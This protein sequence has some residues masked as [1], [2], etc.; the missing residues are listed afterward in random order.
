MDYCKE[1]FQLT[2]AI[3]HSYIKGEVVKDRKKT[4]QENGWHVIV[5]LSSKLR[6]KN[7]GCEKN[8]FEIK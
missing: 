7:K 4:W 2:R 1:R 5:L 8:L 3:L 6:Q